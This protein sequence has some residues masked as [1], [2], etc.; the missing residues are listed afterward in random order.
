MSTWIA[1]LR[2][3]N[4]GGRNIVPM[5]ELRSLLEELGYGQVRTYIQS[6]NCVFESDAADDTKLAGEIADAMEERFGFRPEVMVMTAETLKQAIADN[7][8]A[9]RDPNPSHVHLFFLAEK[10]PDA[11]LDG[12]RTIAKQSEEFLL[13]GQV[14]YLHAPDGI[15]RSVLVERLGRHLPVSMTARNLRTAGKLAEL[16]S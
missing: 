11:D 6:G 12:L 3:I 9:D 14:F 1:L 7:P 15:G 16:A 13:D 8:F 2:G 5:A 4:V 10:T